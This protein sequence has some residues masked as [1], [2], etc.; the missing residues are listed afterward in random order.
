M[1]AR[2]RRDGGELAARSREVMG[3]D[4]RSRE[5]ASSLSWCLD[6]LCL[7]KAEQADMRSTCPG[8]ASGDR[9]EIARRSRRGGEGGGGDGARLSACMPSVALWHSW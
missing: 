1:A 9:A 2:W 3:G 7:Q 8:S 5:L 4:G 6:A